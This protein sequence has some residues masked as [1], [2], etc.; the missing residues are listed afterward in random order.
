[1][2]RGCCSDRPDAARHQVQKVANTRASLSVRQRSSRDQLGSDATVSVG[3][4]DSANAVRIYVTPEAVGARSSSAAGFA[5]AVGVPVE[6]STES[7][8][9]DRPAPPARVATTPTRP[10]SGSDRERHRL[11]AV[12]ARILHRGVR[13]HSGPHGR[14]LRLLRVELV[15]PG[16]GPDT[17]PDGRV[18][19]VQ[20]SLYKQG[21]K[22]VLRIGARPRGVRLGLR[23][24]ERVR[25][26]AERSRSDPQRGRVRVDVSVEH[27]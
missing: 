2:A 7:R 9:K 15:P 11:P 14:P 17:N 10:V 19:S 13:R 23:L 16:I 26:D 12:H 8:G 25:R 6:V 21:G 22:D 3:I 27:Q 18:G 24:R 5:T 4:D 1:M 20:L